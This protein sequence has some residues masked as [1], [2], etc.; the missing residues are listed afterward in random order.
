MEL[1]LGLIL[2]FA[3]LLFLRVRLNQ[4]LYC[5]LFN[6]TK[7]DDVS[8]YIFAILFFPGIVLHET[9]HWITAKILRVK[10]YGFSL[11]PERMEP[12]RVR[13]GYVA[14]G[15][16]DFIRSGLV[17]LAPLVIGIILVTWIDTH[18]LNLEVMLDSFFE[19]DWQAVITGIRDYVYSPDVALWTY[20]LIAI[21][22]MMLPSPTDYITVLPLICA[23]GLIVVVIVLI[24]PP[25]LS[26]LVPSLLQ[27]AW[28]LLYA[29]L[30]TIIFDVL[31]LIPTW[32]LNGLLRRLGR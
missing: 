9:S 14:T 15:K 30:I 31:I 26:S 32:F 16:S 24:N 13:L 21:S 23:L 10:T 1:I 3:V 28:A 8:T 6:L 22:N 19:G 27:A 5:F 2:S 17:G 25:F 4:E 29:F 7:R 18:R 12:G 11:K 20:L